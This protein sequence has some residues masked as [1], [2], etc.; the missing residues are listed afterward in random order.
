ML[1]QHSSVSAGDICAFHLSQKLQVGDTVGGD[2]HLLMQ[3]MDSIH[4]VIIRS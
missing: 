4:A 3:L 1:H 2:V